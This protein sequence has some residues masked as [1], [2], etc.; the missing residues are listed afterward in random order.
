[1]LLCWTEGEE[2]IGWYHLPDAGFA[3]R[4]PIEELTA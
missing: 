2:R 4:K 1:V 3:G